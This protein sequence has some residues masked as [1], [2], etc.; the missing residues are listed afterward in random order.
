M[1][2]LDY[3]LKLVLDWLCDGTKADPSILFQSSPGTK[4]YW[5]TKGSMLL[6]AGVLYQTDKHTDDKRL[7]LPGV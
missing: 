4:Y 7:V 1:E 3:E 6:I 5:L 2:S